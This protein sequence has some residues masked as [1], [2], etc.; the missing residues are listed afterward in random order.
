MF[1][2]NAKSSCLLSSRCRARF[3]SGNLRILR[4]VII[5]I[6]PELF[7]AENNVGAARFPS[8]AE[9]LLRVEENKLYCPLRR[10]FSSLV[11][12]SS[13]SS[14]PAFALFCHS[15]QQR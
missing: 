14:P 8:A 15:R 7:S 11:P 4:L 3:F 6:S 5:K 10:N 9:K 2:V 12:R 13:P 1:M